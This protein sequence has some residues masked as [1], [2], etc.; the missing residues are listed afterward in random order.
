MDISPAP[1]TS[2]ADDPPQANH[3]AAG[4]HPTPV[5]A[6]GIFLDT[7]AGLRPISVGAGA[8]MVPQ[9]VLPA[10]GTPLTTEVF[11]KTL[12][13]NTEHIIKSF[14]SNIGELSKRV[15]ENTARIIEQSQVGIRNERALTEQRVEISVI[16]T[17]LEALETGKI[18]ANPNAVRPAAL[19]DEYNKARRSIRLWPIPGV[20]EDDL[21]EGVGEFIHGPLG[22]SEAE[23]GQNDIEAIY[24]VHS[25]GSGDNVKDEALV[26]LKDKKIR[27]LMMVNSIN[28]AE[29]VDA[30][31]RAT[32]GT[33][34]EV[35]A[36]LLDTFR[37][38]NRFGARLRA[39]H[40][41][42]TKKAY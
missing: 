28:L 15:E 2:T 40:G 34:M 37:L 38:L 26:V 31:G 13:M 10:T 1:L 33:R 5:P 27:D 29:C 17:T 3:P 36:D 32:A 22:V 24:R 19:S 7:S 20:T 6:G 42:G 39:R 21:W 14:T 23:V 25:L 41:P 16:N 11:F 18:G 35:P 4:Q 12:Q 30:A 8:G 9:A